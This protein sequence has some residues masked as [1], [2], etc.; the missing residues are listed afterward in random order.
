MWGLQVQDWQHK[1]WQKKQEDSDR[2][3]LGIQDEA[4]A[5]A[6]D[7]EYGAGCS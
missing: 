2:E 6:E 1:T 5:K 3:L 4:N 7:E